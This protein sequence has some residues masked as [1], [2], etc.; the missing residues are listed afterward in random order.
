MYS[1]A[2]FI[3][4]LRYFFLIGLLSSINMESM[5]FS[6]DSHYHMLQKKITVYEVAARFMDNVAVYDLSNASNVSLPFAIRIVRKNDGASV[7]SKIECVDQEL[8]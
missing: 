2:Y 3:R 1:E 6:I 5:E 8:F 7:W 4:S